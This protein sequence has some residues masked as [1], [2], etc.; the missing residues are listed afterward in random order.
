VEQDYI[1]GESIVFGGD[2][3]QATIAANLQGQVSPMHLNSALRMCFVCFFMQFLT[4]CFYIYDYR[5]L[6][7]FQPIDTDATC[8]RI[9]SSLLL[10]RGSHVK[11]NKAMMILTYLKRAPGKTSKTKCINVIIISMQIMIPI[12][13]VITIMVVIG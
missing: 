13:S 8:L 6:D 2:V 7:N 11:L 12:F 9:I 1:E 3:Y 10:H 4:S 5:H